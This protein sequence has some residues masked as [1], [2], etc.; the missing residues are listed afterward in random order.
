MMVGTRCL[1]D[2]CPHLEEIMAKNHPEHKPHCMVVESKT[3]CLS[4]RHCFKKADG[5]RRMHS[6]LEEMCG[7]CWW[8]WMM[9]VV[10]WWFES[11]T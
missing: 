9:L 7:L 1:R 11:R 2:G 8:S 5:A 4:A 3:T 6:V 10:D